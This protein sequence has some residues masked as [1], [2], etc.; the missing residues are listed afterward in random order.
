MAA[1]ATDDSS[2]SVRPRVPGASAGSANATAADRAAAN[3]EAPPAD[4]FLLAGFE[5]EGSFMSV[6]YARM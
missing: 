3:A 4:V 6:L 1:D 5:H 2:Q